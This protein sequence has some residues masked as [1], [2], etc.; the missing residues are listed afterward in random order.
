[1]QDLRDF[2]AENGYVFD[3]ILNGQFQEVHTEDKK[4]WFVGQRLTRA[5]GSEVIVATVGDWRTGE[6]LTYK[7]ASGTDSESWAWDELI[8]KQTE[9]AKAEKKRRQLLASKKADLIWKRAS[10]SVEKTSPYMKRKKI[11]ELYG[12]KVVEGVLHIPMGGMDENI[13][14]IQKIQ[15]NG[16]KRYLPYQ[17]TM[18]VFCNL[19][20]PGL[21][22]DRL[23]FCEGFATACSL[24]E[25]FPD[26]KV[27]C[28]FS[29]NNLKV[30]PKLFRDHNP[31]GRF[32]IAADNDAYTWVKGAIHNTGVLAAQDVA[33]EV[34]ATV[35]YPSFDEGIESK[36]TDWNDLHCLEGIEAVKEQCQKVHTVKTKE[37]SPQASNPTKKKK[38]K[39]G[40]SDGDQKQPSEKR[41]VALLRD[42]FGD[43]LLQQSGDLFWYDEGYWKRFEPGDYNRLYQLTSSMVGKKAKNNTIESAIAHFKRYVPSP[44]PETNL[45]YPSPTVVCFPNGTL[46][47]VARGPGDYS[48]SF[49]KHS[50]DDFLINQIP[51]EYDESGTVVNTEFM[52]MLDRVFE[53]A[54]DSASRIESIQ[55]MYG[56]C[57]MPFFSRLFLL[58]G[59]SGTGKS[60]VI[61]PLTHLVAKQNF[62]TIEPHEFGGRGFV[63][64]SAAGKLV[65]IVTDIDTNKP[66]GDAHI[67]KIVD[68]VPYR[69]DRKFKEAVYAPLPAVHV[70]GA[71]DIPP[72]LEGGSRAHMRRWTFLEFGAWQLD[73][74]RND[75][76]LDYGHYL[77]EKSPQGILNF[78]VK[79][80]QS[81]VAAQ[82]HFVNPPS[83]WA[84]ME[85]WQTGNDPVA[86][87]M[88]SIKSGD[89]SGLNGDENTTITVGESLQIRRTDLFEIYRSWKGYAPNKGDWQGRIQ[90]YDTLRGSGFGEKTIR[91]VRYFTG[92]GSNPGTA[93]Y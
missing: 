65:N 44:P 85:K 81:L 26:A 62:T 49:G 17:K 22:Y 30:V 64:E 52:T 35:V 76:I 25:A 68:R 38:A 84:R 71:N 88:E 74:K 63:L 11:T 2:L 12:A 43:N 28:C 45:F 77:W 20:H 61:L 3:P 91:G 78:A 27:I 82:G 80:L 19:G 42:H 87:F 4:G 79:G 58:H 75:Y 39:N 56:A 86:S 54:N 1:M 55:Q 21:S 50:K 13:W 73:L 66:I 37:V 14:G 29:A 51:V 60:T 72:T 33:A 92:I 32:I 9:K 90:L 24:A 83:G 53:G 41:I 5:D 34:D 48:L 40:S 46:R 57:L 89:V 16:E 93:Q 10:K 36:P 15:P 18:G 6:K 59:P 69:I 23:I 31:D 67:K 7:G 8:E 70:F 47:L